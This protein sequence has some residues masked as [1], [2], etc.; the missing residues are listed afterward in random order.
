MVAQPLFVQN[1]PGHQAPASAARM[2]HQIFCPGI[3]F[4][5]FRWRRFL[6]ILFHSGIG[7]KLG[8]QIF[9]H[10]SL[11]T[12]GPPLRR[13]QNHNVLRMVRLS[14]EIQLLQQAT[15]QIWRLK[16][17]L[18]LCAM[19]IQNFWISSKTLTTPFTTMLG[20]TCQH[21]RQ[22]HMTQ[23]FFYTIALS[24]IAGHF[25]RSFD[26]SENNGN[27]S[28]QSINTPFHPSTSANTM[29]YKKPSGQ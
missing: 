24:T 18:H 16:S 23:Y 21:W 10:K 14:P 8:C 27:Q 7:L 2:D 6:D 28:F 25:G 12:G 11:P 22:Q 1:S 13:Q 15:Q 4:T 5:Q 29:T 26:I 17:I 9:I 19:T 3:G 20:V